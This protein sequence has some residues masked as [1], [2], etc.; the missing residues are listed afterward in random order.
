MDNVPF[1]RLD[2][3]TYRIPRHGKMW[4][5]AV[6][7]ANDEILAQL[8]AEGYAS[9]K[10]LVNVATLPGIVGPALAM[11]DIH[12]GY[13]FPIGG[14][15]AFD[16]TAGGVV[17][18]GGVGFDINCGV[19]LLT[20]R[21]T[22]ED[23]EPR[24]T[25]LADALYRRVPAGVGSARRD[26]RWSP[27]DLK[28]VLREGAR[29]LVAQGFGEAA[30]LERIESG[31][32][33]P[34]ADP[35]RVSARALERGGPQLGTLGSGNHFLEVQY[36]DEVYDPEAAEAY[37]LWV[38]QVTVLIHT[39]SRGL[40]H[41]VCQDYVERFLQAARR[42]GI[43]LVDRQLAAAPIESPEGQD[44]LHAMAAAANFAFANRQ[45]ITHNVR[46]AF[47]D[48]GFLPRDHQLR[49][50]YDLAHNNAKF[51]EY[52]GRRVLVHRK[53]A[54]RAFGPGAPDVPPAFRTVGQPV[55]VPGDMGRY[56]FVLAG[57]PGA[58]T[59]TFGSSCHGAGR[60]M[61]RHK[62]K[63]AAR[64]RNLIA[65]LEAQGILVRAASRATVDEEMPEAY[66]DV[67]SVVDVVHGAGIGKKVAR[68]RPL[69][70]VKG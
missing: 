30:D 48:A 45:L 42:Y 55:L 61:S 54:T 7:Y 4:V 51:E 46:L 14:V 31:G 39:G 63:K 11:P 10:Q 50:L 6:F 52:A 5:D 8:E 37:G 34:L 13:G 69:I 66:K 19:R 38:G 57:T 22:R 41:Q 53:G 67:A 26:V 28:T 9:L 18:P 49:V 23:L 43:E 56:S 68:L 40:G 27:K 58:M 62:A 21:L 29:A 32:R 16:P 12:W 1:E 20:T 35:D 33:L 47:E 17:S 70:V 44:Y 60:Q 3:Y 24:K 15:A 59:R 64:K 65:E 25:R 2:R 36:V